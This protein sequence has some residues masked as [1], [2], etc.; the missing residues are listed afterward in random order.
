MQI[1]YSSFWKGLVARDSITLD[2]E[3]ARVISE[4]QSDPSGSYDLT[5]TLVEVVDEVP[6]DV[7]ADYQQLAP[8]TRV[9]D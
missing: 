5:T 4:H 8:G 9:S 3:T 6:E 2:R 7:R 1:T